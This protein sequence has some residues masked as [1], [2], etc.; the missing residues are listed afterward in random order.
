MLYVSHGFCLQ[1]SIFKMTVCSHFKSSMLQNVLREYVVF[2]I[3]V[4]ENRSL[5]AV[6]YRG[7]IKILY[8]KAKKIGKVRIFL[9]EQAIKSS[10]SAVALGIPR[11]RA[12]AGQWS[13]DASACGSF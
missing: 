11:N 7:L 2:Y 8:F 6:F 13:R 4:V 1:I 5:C 3:K 9:V 12:V 10:Q